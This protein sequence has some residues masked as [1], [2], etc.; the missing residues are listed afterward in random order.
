MEIIS[1]FIEIITSGRISSDSI[2]PLM[3]FEIFQKS[4]FIGIG[5]GSVKTTDMGFLEIFIISGLL[6]LLL[7]LLIFVIILLK[8]INFSKSFKK[9]RVFLAFIWIILLFSTI[10]GSAMTTNRVSIFIWVITTLILI[11]ISNEKYSLRMFQKIKKN[12]DK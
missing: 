5:Y 9:E 6:G 3:F 4:P 1:K 10:G 11:K 7:Y 8:T 2:Q 12:V